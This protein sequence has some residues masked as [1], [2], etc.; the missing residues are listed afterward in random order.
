VDTFFSLVL[1][2]LYLK[3]NK[4][5]R[6]EK[7]S[8][9]IPFVILGTLGHG[10]AHGAMAAKFRSGGEGGEE[11]QKPKLWQLVAFAAV[12]WFPLLKASLIKVSS[13]KVALLAALVTCGGIFLKEQYG[14]A[15]VQTVLS[16]AYHASQLL[17][18]VKEKE[19]REYLTLPLLV[20]VPPLVTAWNEALFCGAYFKSLGGHV[21]YD[22]S[23]IIG[24]IGYFIDS[25]QHVTKRKQKTI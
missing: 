18:P 8:E 20:A 17:L 2:A 9:I 22:A 13:G 23:I 3:W 25:Y 7:A 5:P 1:G 16:V 12:F 19:H 14:F 24:T 21:L 6:M 4:I 11:T 15:Y 10:F